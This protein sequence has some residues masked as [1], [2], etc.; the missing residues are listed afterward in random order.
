MA[1]HSSQFPEKKSEQKARNYSKICI[2]QNCEHH[3]HN[4]NEFNVQMFR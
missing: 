1:S 2:I 4:T 3:N